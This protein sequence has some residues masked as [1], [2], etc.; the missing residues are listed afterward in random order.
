LLLPENPSF[1]PDILLPMVNLDELLDLDPKA[2]R[3]PFVSEPAFDSSGLG[4]SVSSAP[5]PL[6]LPSDSLDFP[7]ADLLEDSRWNARSSTLDKGQDFLVDDDIIMIDDNGV[8]LDVGSTTQTLQAQS[9]ARASGAM[10]GKG[11]ETTT[12]RL[13]QLLRNLQ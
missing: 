13:L 12:V 10:D 11:A 9:R 4:P 7:D 3:L 5:L 2:L 8:I 6:A 1:L